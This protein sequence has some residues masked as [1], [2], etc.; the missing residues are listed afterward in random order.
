MKVS[1]GGE[2]RE[3]LS[4]PLPASSEGVG[5]GEGAWPFSKP[6]GVRR[7]SPLAVSTVRSEEKAL[8]G[9]TLCI[10]EPCLKGRAYK[11]FGSFSGWQESPWAAGEPG[12]PEGC[13]GGMLR[14]RGTRA[15]SRQDTVL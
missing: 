10:N 14:P 3:G 15:R 6:G 5:A 7:E 9:A 2:G 13:S 8:F 4:C 12:T 11:R 1:R